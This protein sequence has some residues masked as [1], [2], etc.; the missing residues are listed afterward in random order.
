MHCSDI[1][2]SCGRALQL[3]CMQYRAALCDTII[4]YACLSH[5]MAWHGMALAWHCMAQSY[6][7]A[8]GLTGR[9]SVGPRQPLE[10]EGPLGPT[11]HGRS[12]ARRMARV[13]RLGI[14]V[15]LTCGGSSV[16]AH[17]W[18]LICELMSLWPSKSPSKPPSKTLP[19]I[20]G[21]LHKK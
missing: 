21:L 1:Y 8:G 2:K 19:F 9:L 7:R 12:R 11:S 18:E 17:P 3:K 4:S 13:L 20:Y 14:N 15:S 10:R 6:W 16:G 5:G